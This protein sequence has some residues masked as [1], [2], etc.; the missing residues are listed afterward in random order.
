MA[1]IAK[2]LGGRWTGSRGPS[3]R[4]SWESFT[5]LICV[6]FWVRLHLKKDLLS[7]HAWLVATLMRDADIERAGAGSYEWTLR[8]CAAH[9]L[10]SEHFG[11]V[12][13]GRTSCRGCDVGSVL[14]NTAVNWWPLGALRGMV[15]LRGQIFHLFFIWITIHGWW[16]P[17]WH[18]H[19]AVALVQ[20][21]LI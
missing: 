15:Q 11:T 17:N 1:V 4:F 7:R 18:C 21:F 19:L 9:W 20:R 2:D 6:G 16:L 10:A 8:D 14:S 5:F 13:P 3:L 12:L